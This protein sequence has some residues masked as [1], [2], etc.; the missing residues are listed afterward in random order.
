MSDGLSRRAFVGKLAVGAAAA[1]AAGV[2][3]QAVSAR[4]TPISPLGRVDADPLTSLLTGPFP[5]VTAA[6]AGA[7]ALAAAEPPVPESLPPWELLRPLSLGS[8]VTPEWRVGGVTGIA[9]GSCV[10][11]LENARGRAQRIHLCGNAGRPQGLVYTQRV[12]L[13][14]MNGGQGDLPTEEGFAQAVAE[15]AHVVAAN[16][17][18]QERVVTALLAHAER[19]ERFAA[20]AQ[21]R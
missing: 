5:P 15:V 7:A 8:A 9:D 4:E 20:A 1:C 11:T 18:G 3:A 17:G 10:L 21:L 13:V 14:V 12:D 6:A 16:E 19:V 2:G